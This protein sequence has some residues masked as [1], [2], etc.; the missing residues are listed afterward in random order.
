MKA[1]PQC[2]SFVDVARWRIPASLHA[3]D[4]GDVSQLRPRTQHTFEGL[5]DNLRSESKPLRKIRRKV[6]RHP[7]RLPDNT[8]MTQAQP[9]ANWIGPPSL[10]Q[11]LLETL[12]RAFAMLWSNLVA[13]KPTVV[14]SGGGGGWWW[15]IVF[16]HAPKPHPGPCDPIKE[17]DNAAASSPPTNAHHSWKRPIRPRSPRKRGSSLLETR[18]V[19][20]TPN[21]FGVPGFPPSRETRPLAL[22]LLA[23]G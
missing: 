2:T 20:S 11:P 21:P 15:V 1:K 13:P 16:R 5:R 19:R 7:L 8:R 3:P 12:L 4:N 14:A 17:T 9:R 10:C 18:C 6:I 22:R 23:T